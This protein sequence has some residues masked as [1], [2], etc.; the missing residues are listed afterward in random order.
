MEAIKSIIIIFFVLFSIL[1][2]FSHIAKG[3]EMK[4]RMPETILPGN[5]ILYRLI[6]VREIG[7]KKTN[8]T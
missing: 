8:K 6:K 5:L 2:R 1:F 4:S 3:F 7:G